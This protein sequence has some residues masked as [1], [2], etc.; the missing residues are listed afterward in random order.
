MAWCLIL[1]TCSA[2]R[3][4]CF[5]RVASHTPTTLC[6]GAGPTG[7]SATGPRVRPRKPSRS[8]RVKRDASSMCGSSRRWGGRWASLRPRRA[9]RRVLFS[10]NTLVFLLGG[11]SARVPYRCPTA[12]LEKGEPFRER[13]PRHSV[14]TTGLAPCASQ[15]VGP[16]SMKTALGRRSLG[17]PLALKNPSTPPPKAANGKE[18]AHIDQPIQVAVRAL[19]PPTSCLCSLAPSVT[20]PLYRTTVSQA[21]RQP[22]RGLFSE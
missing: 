7:R 4:S 19:I 16:F 15:P 9:T 13:G 18:I 3:V 5:P 2:I 22:L 1:R 12:F 10:L 17:M 11:L 8:S 14:S 21:L 6:F 20:T